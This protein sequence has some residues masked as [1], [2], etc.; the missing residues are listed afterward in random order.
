M[1]PNAPTSS[2]ETSF[3]ADGPLLKRHHAFW[4]L[5]VVESVLVLFLVYE[6]KT[7]FQVKARFAA[8]RDGQIEAVAQAE[9]ASAQVQAVLQDL[10]QLSASD[11]QAKALLDKYHIQAGR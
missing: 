4:L 11:P 7:A 3:P 1:T 5:V 10:L 9:N 6:L 2:A 8:F